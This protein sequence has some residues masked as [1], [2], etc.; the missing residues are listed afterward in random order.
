[1]THK[2]T[3]EIEAEDVMIADLIKDGIQNIVNELEPQQLNFLIDLSDKATAQAYKKKL[4]G[5]IDN[6]LVKALATRI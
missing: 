5:V 6:P 2:V 3:I 4:M 1:M